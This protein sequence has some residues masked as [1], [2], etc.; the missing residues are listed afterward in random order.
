M[1]FAQ[2]KFSIRT[3]IGADVL[4]NTPHATRVRGSVRMSYARKDQ[5]WSTR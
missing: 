4:F 2:R 1:G 3:P 5:G